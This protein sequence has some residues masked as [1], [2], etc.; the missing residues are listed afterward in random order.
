LAVLVNAVL[1]QACFV[2][3][4]NL[5]VALKKILQAQL[6][7]AMVRANLLMQTVKRKALIWALQAV[8]LA[9][10]DGVAVAAVLK[11]GQF[12]PLVEAQ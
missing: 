5:L 9:C 8:I 2:R 6:V 11:V 4:K 7:I 10:R 1:A 12:V 3:S